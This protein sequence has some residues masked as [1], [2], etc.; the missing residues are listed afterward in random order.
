MT[1]RVDQVEVVDLAV[2]RLVLQG[3]GLRLDGDATLFLKVHGV[4]NLRAHLALLQTAT[5][6]D[7]PVGQRG[8]A[9]IDMGNDRKISDVVHQRERL[10]A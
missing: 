4:Q 10:S 2:A 9:V 3:R 1:G 5:A 7:E 6:L 8:F